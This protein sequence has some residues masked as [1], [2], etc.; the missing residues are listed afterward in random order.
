M[1]STGEGSLSPTHIETGQADE[2]IS[3]FRHVAPAATSFVVVIAKFA[4]VGLDGFKPAAR[5]DVI[6][7]AN[8]SFLISCAWRVWTDGRTL[9]TARA[10]TSWFTRLLLVVER[11][12]C[13]IVFVVALTWAGGGSVRVIQTYAELISYVTYLMALAYFVLGFLI[14]HQFNLDRY[15]RRGLI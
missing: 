5:T 4:S 13:T 3:F 8:V 9:A 15:F 10:P 11:A 7:W 2:R 14:F 6:L 12:W 1:T